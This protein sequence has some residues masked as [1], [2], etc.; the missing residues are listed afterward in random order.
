MNKKKR[1]RKE[2]KEEMQSRV[3]MDI[4]MVEEAE[5]MKIEFFCMKL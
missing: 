3:W 1:K 2:E 5:K 4:K